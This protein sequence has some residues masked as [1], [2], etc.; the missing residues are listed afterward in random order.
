MQIFIVWLN[1]KN[2]L[3][4]EQC[5]KMARLLFQYLVIYSI[6]N[7]QNSIRNLP[8][9]FQIFA[10]YLMNPIKFAQVV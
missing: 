2:N 4:I 9:Y 7:L 1:V 10:K 3:T 5:D 6:D 8:K